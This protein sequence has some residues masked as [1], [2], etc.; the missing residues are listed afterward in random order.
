MLADSSLLNS[1]HDSGVA[2][3]DPLDDI[4]HDN[5]WI[6]GYGSLIYKP[7]PDVELAVPGFITGYVRRFW[8][9]SHDHRGTPAAPGR[10]VTLLERTYWE[11]LQDA[12]APYEY[13]GNSDGRTWGI[14]YKIIA[15]KVQSVSAALDL[16]EKNGYTVHFVP[17][18]PS[19]EFISQTC[20]PPEI[21]A[22]VYI[23]TPSN[24]AFAGVED[25][26][27]VARLIFESTGP[28]GTNVEYLYRLGEALEHLHGSD[29]SASEYH[30]AD[31]IK[32]VKKLE[33]K[34]KQPLDSFEDFDS[35]AALS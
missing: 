20:L 10:V 34:S 19:R 2:L 12:H 26:D 1:S 4:S 33:L 13:D 7:P 29:I 18:H 3:Y 11:T 35:P 17:F 6:F 32:R 15:E 22:I 9:K 24:F 28:S 14:A 31:L 5:F 25:P 27:Y 8:Q 21:S 23:G 30:V 16:R